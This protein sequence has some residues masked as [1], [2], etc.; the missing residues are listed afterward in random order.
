MPKN[1]STE[2]TAENQHHPLSRSEYEK[3]RLEKLKQDQEAY[4]RFRRR[5]RERYAKWFASL[6]DEEKSA[7]WKESRARKLSKDPDFDKR[8]DAKRKTDPRRVASKK[9]VGKIYRTKNRERYNKH[10]MA[11]QRKKMLTDPYFRTVRYLRNRQNRA[12]KQAGQ[13]KMGTSFD[14][15]GCDRVTLL[16][17]IESLFQPGMTWE[18]RGMEPGTWQIDHVV[19]I[20]RFNLSTIE[21]QRSAFRFTNLQPL[22]YEDHLRKSATE[23]AGWRNKKAAE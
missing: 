19:P 1:T 3:K 9:A 18:N 21:S 20:F 5:A 23:E 2:P 7:M 16:R 13:D 14:L 10:N 11:W 4:S 8:H 6:S 15:L 12:I 17:H 22:W